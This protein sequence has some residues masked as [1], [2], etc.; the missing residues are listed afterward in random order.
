VPTTFFRAAAWQLAEVVS[1][2]PWL[3][4]AYGFGLPYHTRDYLFLSAAAERMLASDDLD[5]I[6]I[7]L[8][9]PHLPRM[10]DRRRRRL[11]GPERQQRDAYFDNL[12]FAD[13]ELA[14][15]LAALGRSRR[16]PETTLIVTSDHPY[17]FSA[18]DGL[19]GGRRIPFLVT[20][21][22]VTREY[23]PLGIGETANCYLLPANC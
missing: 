12:A 21:R 19:P 14:R 17:R 10:Y 23:T 13:R 2:G 3:D 20:G 15:L 16:A 8:P 6:W 11:V 9:L 18:R 1:V 5:V 4:R 7:H 22:N